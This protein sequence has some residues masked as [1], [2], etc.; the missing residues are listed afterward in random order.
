MPVEL[1]SAFHT[2]VADD[3]AR[4]LRRFTALCAQGG[5]NPKALAR[6]LQ[7]HSSGFDPAQLLAGLE[8][9]AQLDTSADLRNYQGA[10]LHL[11]A[12]N[13]ALVPQAAI[14]I[15]QKYAPSAQVLLLKESSHAVVYEQAERV[16]STMANFM[17]RS[18]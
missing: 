14:T 6:D 3:C 4:A 9:L 10:Q 8:L 1:F 11:L 7:Q 17:R 15:V 2:S 13:D 5:Q 18:R 12:D 16:A